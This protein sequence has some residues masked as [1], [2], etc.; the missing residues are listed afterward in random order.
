MDYYIKFLRDT[1]GLSYHVRKTGFSIYFCSSSA[2]SFLF[3]FFAYAFPNAIWHFFF[4]KKKSRIIYISVFQKKV[5]YVMRKQ[6]FSSIIIYMCF[7]PLKLNIHVG[8]V[9]GLLVVLDPGLGMSV[10]PTS[11][12]RRCLPKCCLGNGPVCMT[13]GRI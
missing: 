1:Q 12:F 8:K 13:Q 6:K 10:V 7:L 2:H 3:T 5:S 4:L 11:L 9:Y